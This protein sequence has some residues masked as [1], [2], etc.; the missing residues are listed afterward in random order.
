[1]TE[2][3]YG[4]RLV[5]A[6]FNPSGNPK[7]DELK[8]VTAAL[9]DLMWGYV[10]ELESISMND[11]TELQMV[12]HDHKIECLNIAMSRVEEAAMWAVKGVT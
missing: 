8:I 10:E 11:M 1:M 7:V 6:S 3:T 2:E 9:I 4:Q 12:A 5:R